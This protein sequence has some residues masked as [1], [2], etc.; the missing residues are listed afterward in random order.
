MPS[1]YYSMEF[2]FL[3][4]LILNKFQSTLRFD[5]TKLEMLIVL[6][7]IK[8]ILKGPWIDLFIIYGYIMFS[9]TL[10]T[11]YSKLL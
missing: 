11:I 1:N 7:L 6:E 9:P 8:D 10:W 5:K 4:W 2:Y 3:F